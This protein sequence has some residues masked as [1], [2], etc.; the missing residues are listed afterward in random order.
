MEDSFGSPLNSSVCGLHSNGSQYCINYKTW[1]SDWKAF[2]QCKV[3]GG[4][5]YCTDEKNNRNVC[6]GSHPKTA[7][8]LLFFFLLNYIMGM[9]TCARLDGRRWI[10]W[11]TVLFNVYPQY[12]K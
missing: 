7:S 9:V 11:I 10:P 4:D 12:C 8:S 6:G 3:H 1:S 2:K 5:K